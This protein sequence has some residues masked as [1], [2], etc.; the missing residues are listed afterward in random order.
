[1]ETLKIIPLFCLLFFN[2][3]AQTKKPTEKE[4]K[5]K[6]NITVNKEF[7]EFGNLKRYDSVYSYSY[8]S[9]EKLNDSLHQKFSK[10]LSENS[11]FKDSFFEDFFNQDSAANNFKHPKFFFNQFEN[12][13]THINNMMKYMDSIQQQFF[14]Y[15]NAPLIPAE[16]EKTIHKYS[17]KI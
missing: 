7:D 12:N 2:C 9:H 13:N 8:S 6:E 10:L 3:S 17:K 14:N 5:P 15:G 1:M 4:N 16:P 11:I